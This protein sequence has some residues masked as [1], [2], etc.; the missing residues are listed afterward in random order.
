ML[1]DITK[2]EMFHD[3]FESLYENV[4]HIE[5]RNEYAVGSNLKNTFL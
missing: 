1:N 2:P 4:R 3:I 5:L